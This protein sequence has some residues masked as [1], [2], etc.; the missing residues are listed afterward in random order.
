MHW[1]LY[2]VGSISSTPVYLK[3][4][5]GFRKLFSRDEGNLLIASGIK[6]VY[7]GRIRLGSSL[8]PTAG[9]SE[10]HI[11]YVSMANTSGGPSLTKMGLAF[12]CIAYRGMIYKTPKVFSKLFYTEPTQNNCKRRPRARVALYIK[13]LLAMPVSP[14]QVTKLNLSCFLSGKIVI[15]L[16]ASALAVEQVATVRS[17]C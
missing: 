11:N 15:S 1:Q 2:I 16:D 17:N 3:Q 12:C 14:Y 5:Y 4:F 8:C 7:I 10:R 6:L 9:D 13:I